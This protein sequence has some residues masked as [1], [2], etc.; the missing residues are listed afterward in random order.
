EEFGEAHIRTGRPILYTSADSVLQIAAHEQ[1]FGLERLYA[2][3]RTMRTLTL[4]LRIGRVIARPFIGARRGEFRRTANRKDWAIEPAQPTLLDRLYAQGRAIVTIGKIGDIFA[5]R[6]TGEE[7]KAAGND[8][9][10]NAALA[11]FDRLPVGGLVFANLVDFDVEFGHRRDVPGYAAA[12]EA[13]DRR[14]PEIAARLRPGD[15]A[16]I[17]ADHGNDPTWR[18]TDH[19]R[20]R[21]PVLA[22]GP[23]IA[24]GSIGVRESLAD[25]AASLA[26]HLGIPP[27]PDGRSFLQA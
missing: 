10:L 6:A 19:T 8:S 13:F 18:G 17:T 12:L 7:I 20:E 2:I 3:C 27:G 21:V 25:I 22:F 4:P 23:G 24:P 16:V 5:H 9:L 14:V 11:A 1:H 15:L 26:V